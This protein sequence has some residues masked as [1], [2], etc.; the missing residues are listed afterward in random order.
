[1]CADE[2]LVLQ[3]S[4]KISRCWESNP[5]HTESTGHIFSR[6]PSCRRWQAL[7]REND[8]GGVLEKEWQPTPVFLPGRA[9]WWTSLEGYSALGH[10]EP[11]VTRWLTLPS[12]RW[13]W[14]TSGRAPVDSSASPGGQQV[15]LPSQGLS[16]LNMDT[17]LPL[18]GSKQRQNHLH[19]GISAVTAVGTNRPPKSLVLWP[20]QHIASENMKV[21]L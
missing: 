7:Q 18:D 3:G 4:R 8:L 2:S 17:C 21:R 20:W 11:D 15:W 6:L 19:K 1:M 16:A 10:K 5:S 9:H 14:V 12:P 13:H